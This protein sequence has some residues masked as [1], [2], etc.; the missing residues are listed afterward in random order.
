MRE[1]PEG[2]NGNDEATIRRWARQFTLGG[3]GSD[4]IKDI[5]RGCYSY[6]CV[7]SAT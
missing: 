1:Y 2:A 6:I 4:C 5:T 3:G 7:T